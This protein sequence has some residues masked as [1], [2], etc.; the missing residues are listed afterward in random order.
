MAMDPLDSLISNVPGWLERLEELSSQIEQR[1]EDSPQ[2][3]SQSSTRFIRH[4]SF[5][6]QGTETDRKTALYYHISFIQSSLEDVLKSISSRRNL[7]RKATLAAK[8]ARIKWLGNLELPEDVGISELKREGSSSL[9]ENR[10][11]LE[12]RTQQS[13]GPFSPQE[14]FR[15]STLNSAPMSGLETSALND[16]SES[17]I[18]ASDNWVELDKELESTQS[19]CKYAANLLLQDGACNEEIEGIKSQL[20]HV[21]D[22]AVSEK[23]IISNEQTTSKTNFE[24]SR[25]ADREAGHQYTTGVKIATERIQHLLHFKDFA[26]Q[27]RMALDRARHAKAKADKDAKLIELRRFAD[28]FKIPTPVPHDLVDIIA[29][30]PAKQH[31]IQEKA[32]RDVLEVAKRKAEEAKKKGKKETVGATAVSQQNAALDA[33]IGRKSSYT[34]QVPFPSGMIHGGQVSAFQAQNL[35]Q[36]REG[37]MVESS[38]QSVA[39]FARNTGTIKDSVAPYEESSRETSPSAGSVGSLSII[40]VGSK[41]NS[42]EV[43]IEIDPLN[44]QHG[45]TDMEYSRRVERFADPEAWLA[46]LER[47][48]NEVIAGSF[49]DR[50][51]SPLSTRIEEHGLAG[52]HSIPLLHINPEIKADRLLTWEHEDVREIMSGLLENLKIMQSSGYCVDSI[53]FL[54][55][56]FSRPS[57]ARLVDVAIDDVNSLADKLQ[58]AFNHQDSLAIVGA[59]SEFLALL[60]FT[61][62]IN[63]PGVFGISRS[64]E[65]KGKLSQHTSLEK[66]R[67]T[68]L[69]LDLAIL[70]YSG[71]HVENL[72][73]HLPSDEDVELLATAGF[74][75]TRRRLNCLNAYLERPVWVFEMSTIRGIQDRS[76]ALYLSTTIADFASIWGPVWAVTGPE[77][78]D[79]IV[80]YN[81]GLGSIVGSERGSDEPEPLKGEVFCHWIPASKDPSPGLHMNSELNGDRML[82][83]GKLSLN[84][85]CKF[86]FDNFASN[87]R[88]NCR[89]VPLPARWGKWCTDNRTINT[90]LGGS[91]FAIG[92]S[93]S[94]K[95]HHRPYREA[96]ADALLHEDFDCCLV[97]LQ[98]RFVVEISAC[99]GLSRRR[100]LRYALGYP[101]MRNYM[102]ASD[103]SWEKEEWEETY[104]QILRQGDIPELRRRIRENGFG[105]VIKKALKKSMLNVLLKTGLDT[106]R[107]LIAFWMSSREDAPYAVSYPFRDYKWVGLLQEGSLGFNMAI[108]SSIC[109]E[110]PGGDDD[111][112]LTCTV[113]DENPNRYSLLETYLLVNN[114]LRVQKR[115]PKGLIAV[116]Y[117]VGDHRECWSV[118]QVEAGE[119]FDLGEHG[120]L[121]VVK[122]LMPSSPGAESG[123]VVEWTDLTP[124]RAGYFYQI[125]RQAIGITP[126]TLCHR[127]YLVQQRGVHMA[128][129]LIHVISHP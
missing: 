39:E 9:S 19:M 41:F 85:S 14:E 64:L 96:L 104:F 57:V 77:R 62:D 72:N 98:H 56:E 84:N 79:T 53:N 113:I 121:K 28:N 74:L 11:S 93:E 82:I 54:A 108:V 129:I 117:E 5:V 92:G 22:L 118:C 127:E 63:G 35:L 90:S 36:P 26:Q 3:S 81:V 47:M 122:V 91:G 99:T 31:E 76:A 55:L 32:D 128:P 42:E 40:P 34:T 16:Q 87:M 105:S 126:L 13:R 25:D 23:E 78:P 97:A 2:F 15:T 114:E 120:S 12:Q 24:P 71:A 30:D 45:E 73:S 100:T 27:Q 51:I 46:R 50:K 119:K 89:L 106:S 20:T 66:A 103:L 43:D 8:V 65:S 68:V 58:V 61:T 49:I 107:E 125:A 29:K 102:G 17:A 86:D 109:L 112:A 116:N 101:G 75:L 10:E 70:S 18:E 33:L 7:V 60:E 48:R 83:G 124:Y 4:Q 111:R 44:P 6:L 38:P 69:L 115:L 123:L 88:D 1:Q 67:L 80:R 110:L 52:P 94:Y 37:I 59:C 21:K 95:L